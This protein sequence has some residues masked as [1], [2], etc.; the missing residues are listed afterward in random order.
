MLFWRLIFK[1]VH[2]TVNRERERAPDIDSFRKALFQQHW[3]ACLLF[4]FLNF[5]CLCQLV[6]SCRVCVLF[7]VMLDFMQA[8]VRSQVCQSFIGACMEAFIRHVMAWVHGT[9]E[10]WVQCCEFM[11]SFAHVNYFVLFHLLYRV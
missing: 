2:W 11:F 4:F 7:I 10:R 1:A 9:F 8:V 6:H 3:A 5:I